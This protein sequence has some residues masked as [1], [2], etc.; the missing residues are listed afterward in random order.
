MVRNLSALDWIA[1]ILVIVGGLNWGLIGIF[2]WDL[3]AVIFGAMSTISQVV[4][5]LVGIAAVYLAVTSGKLAR[6]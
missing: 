2:S 4:Y 5:I 3:I 1:V 6:K